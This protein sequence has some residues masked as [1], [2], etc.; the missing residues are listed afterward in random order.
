MKKSV[1]LHIGL[2]KTA[3]STLQYALKTNRKML[4]RGRLYYP[5]AGIVGPGHHNLAWSILLDGR[6]RHTNGGWQ[7]LRA[8]IAQL[9]D[10][11]SIVIS[12]EEF[13]RIPPHNFAIIR[14]ILKNYALS[15]IFVVRELK[16]WIRSQY[17]EDVKN[18]SC[19]SSI[20]EFASSLLEYDQRTRFAPFLRNVIDILDAKV[21]LFKYS[22]GVI[23]ELLEFMGAD[24]IERA[25]NIRKNRSLPVEQLAEIA[26]M[27]KKDICP[28][29]T[30]FFYSKIGPLLVR[31]DAIRGRQDFRRRE[32]EFSE[33]IVEQIAD[34][35]AYNMRAVR[36]IDR[37]IFW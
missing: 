6:Y 3:T 21:Y 1:L 33:D 13:S 17:A 19:I 25:S 20:D 28:P 5:N 2:H 31:R 8:E 30:E 12:S 4:P 14:E 10:E 35:D 23:E 26:V 34:R 27:R 37:V 32:F 16:S 15:V 7:N 11:F 29:W 9:P 18:G 22:E 36:E 24:I